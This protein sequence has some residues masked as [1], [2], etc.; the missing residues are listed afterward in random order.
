MQ[1]FRYPY[2]SA[3]SIRPD[4]AGIVSI[5]TSKRA[6]PGRWWKITGV[7]FQA[8]FM[9]VNFPL[10]A[11]EMS[12]G[13]IRRARLGR[14]TGIPGPPVVDPEEIGSLSKGPCELPG[15]RRCSCDSCTQW[16]CVAHGALSRYEPSRRGISRY[17]LTSLREKRGAKQ[18]SEAQLSGATF[19]VAFANP[20][21]ISCL[22]I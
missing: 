7:M 12:A 15:A 10:H 9:G 4:P 18:P 14:S 2:P 22:F 21:T 3:Q 19:P 8:C 1:L 17:W 6:C 16:L 20:T 13:A 5:V 11:G